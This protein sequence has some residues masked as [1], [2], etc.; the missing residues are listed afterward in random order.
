MDIAFS[1]DFSYV[2]IV[3]S[4]GSYS[5]AFTVRWPIKNLYLWQKEAHQ[6]LSLP[7]TEKENF[8]NK[9]R[10]HCLSCHHPLIWRDLIP[11]VSYLFLLGKCHYCK[12]P[13][14]YRY[15][16]IELLHLILCLPLM[17]LFQDPYQLLLHTLLV[18]SLITAAAIDAEYK[19]IP[20][21]CTVVIFACALLIHIDKQTLESSILGLL[22]GYGFLYLLHWFYLNIRKQ[23]GMG[24]GDVKLVGALGS[25]LGL[26]G[27]APLLLYASLIGILYTAAL[28]KNKMEQI[29]FGPFLILS[30]VLV[31]YF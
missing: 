23:E 22:I 5:A 17:W 24:L 8:L 28:N 11:L 6:L 18:S 19:L 12:Q 27:L 3:L 30:S 10:S 26:T 14:S 13:I 7:F 9:T 31:F 16:A 4:L 1:I 21:E 15:P 20:D 29:A 2:L 25:W